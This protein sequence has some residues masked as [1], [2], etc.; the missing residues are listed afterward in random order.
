MGGIESMLKLIGEAAAADEIEARWNELKRLSSSAEPPGYRKRYTSRLTEDF[1]R[2]VFNACVE[3]GFR[4][5]A[6]Q[7]RNPDAFLSHAVFDAWTEFKRH[8]ADFPQYEAS[9]LKSLKAHL[10]AA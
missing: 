2:C 5:F 10:L 8:P 1:A 4:G 9:A 3:A 7:Q 6:E